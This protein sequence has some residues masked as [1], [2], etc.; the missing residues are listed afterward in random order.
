MAYRT[1]GIQPLYLCDIRSSDG[2]QDVLEGM[3][4][5][6]IPVKPK[7]DRVEHILSVTREAVET[8]WLVRLDDDEIPSAALIGWLDRSVEGINVPIIALSCRYVMLV[9]GRL[10]FSRLEDY[11]FHPDPT[12]LDPQWRAFRPREVDFIDTIHTPGFK[13][14]R[15]ETAPL[16]AFFIHFDW[17]LRSYTERRAKLKRYERQS[18]GAG[19]QLARYYLPELHTP[20]DMRW[21]PIETDEFDYLARR[22][23]Q[24]SAPATSQPD[25][26][27]R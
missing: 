10:C 3:G 9:D 5:D 16:W 18:R 11:Y 13:I 1:L 26:P 2:T 17:L 23:V 27:D 12:Y 15:Y 7:L 4:A 21:T 19:W 6:M 25:A 8:D 22:L 24:I 14:T 20:E